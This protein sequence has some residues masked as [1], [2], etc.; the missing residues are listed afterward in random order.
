ML[1]GEETVAPSVGVRVRLSG[2]SVCG[3]TPQL[4]V[5]CEEP[6][7]GA[8][9]FRKTIDDASPV[10]HAYVYYVAFHHYCELHGLVE[11][12]DGGDGRVVQAHRAVV[13][14]E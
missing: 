12:G 13:A 1:P 3:I 6:Q 4:S 8:L 10:V 7:L 5:A 11:S 2:E 14:V 9:L